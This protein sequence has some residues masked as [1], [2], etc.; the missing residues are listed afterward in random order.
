MGRYRS[1]LVCNNIKSI[2]L[3]KKEITFK[4]QYPSFLK[5][6]QEY[7]DKLLEKLLEQQMNPFVRKEVRGLELNFSID[8]EK[9]EKLGG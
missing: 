5:D 2:D 6:T 7:A 1:L 3:E 8:D 4:L 9:A